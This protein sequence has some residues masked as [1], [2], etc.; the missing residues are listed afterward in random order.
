MGERT[1]YGYGCWPWGDSAAC[2]CVEEPKPGE[3]EAQ[4][5]ARISRLGWRI[6]HWDGQ[7]YYVCPE[8]RDAV[9]DPLPISLDPDVV[10]ELEGAS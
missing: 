4:Y 5:D 2:K 1:F 8:H 3:T 9:W 10:E 6:G 7:A